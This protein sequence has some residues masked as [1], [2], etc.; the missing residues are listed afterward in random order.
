M[1]SGLHVTVDARPLDIEYLRAQG[2][3]RHAHGLLG[4][5]AEVARERGGRLDMLRAGS[6]TASPFG[7]G[8]GQ[9]AGA[10]RLRRPPFPA[11]Y[12][13]VLEQVAMPF[14][15]RRI[16]PAVHHSLSLYRSPVFAGVPHVMT[17]HD[18]VPLM[19]PERYLRTG[20]LHKMLYRA[21]VRADLLLA[22]SQAARSDIVAHLPVDPG[23]VQVVPLAADERYAPADPAPLRDRL[24]I[25]GP[26]LVW[27]GGLATHDPRKDLEGLI[28]GFAHWQ[29][30]EGRQETLMLAGGIGPA[31]Q[32]LRRQAEATGGRIV[33]P[34]FV[35]DE[36]L[37]ALYSGAR[38]MV[39]ASRYEGFGL[40]A[41]EAIACGTPVVAYDVG[42]VPEVAGPGGLYVTDGDLPALM[43]AAGRVCD[44]EGLHARLR[45]EG[46]GHAARY[47][48]RRSAELTWD[49]YERV[50]AA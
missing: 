45:A 46:L 40:P 26:Y 28:S 30:Q 48:W 35:P 15:L 19:W 14:D 24:G 42:A 25:G 9:G 23:R 49:A 7:A 21:A 11:R 32:E 20:T 31:G 44:D 2:I 5:L 27:V 22:I 43:R 36:D 37:P 4:P 47:S 13:D 34:G 12:A 41:L 29:R 33:F 16:R 1:S 50:A 17:L 38:C 3:G 8:P 39:T 18:V 6:A 10:R